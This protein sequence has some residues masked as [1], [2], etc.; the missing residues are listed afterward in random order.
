[1]AAVTFTT[2]SGES[3]P[4]AAL[5]RAQTMLGNMR[6]ALELA[7]MTL[8]QGGNLETRI[9]ANGPTVGEVIERGLRGEP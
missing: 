8:R 4:F 7:K 9:A 1:V 6:K 2:L 5:E 3:G